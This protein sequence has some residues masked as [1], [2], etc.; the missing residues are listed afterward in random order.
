MKQNS[1]D[2]SCQRL[3]FAI[4]FIPRSDG[5]K[6]RLKTG[7]EHSSLLTKLINFISL[8]RL[9]MR[10][11]ESDNWCLNGLDMRIYR[12]SKILSRCNIKVVRRYYL[13]LVWWR[14]F[15][16]S[17]VIE[18]ALVSSVDKKHRS[19][20]NQDV[21]YSLVWIIYRYPWCE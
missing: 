20:L 8:V 17:D 15:E 5:M 16:K 7:C 21:R 11:V 12:M 19:V 6:N 4:F 14:Y 10:M 18:L 13:L 1:D 9:R 2:L 3:R